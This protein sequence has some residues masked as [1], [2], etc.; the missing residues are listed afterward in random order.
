MKKF[1]VPLAITVFIFL[2]ILSNNSWAGSNVFSSDIEQY[3]IKF[4]RYTNFAAMYS[5]K[6]E[7]C[8]T[9][10]YIYMAA[11]DKEKAEDFLSCY[12]YNL[13]QARLSMELAEDYY[14]LIKFTVPSL[15]EE[16][17]QESRLLKIFEKEEDH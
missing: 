4:L 14:T 6:A 7:S 12:D 16:I 9:D 5:V 13:E 2:L 17:E 3:A 11:G 10:Y 15:P 8:K 1:Q